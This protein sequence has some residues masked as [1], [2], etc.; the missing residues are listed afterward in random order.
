MLVG[1]ALELAKIEVIEDHEKEIFIEHRKKY[2]MLR[3]SELLNSQRVESHRY[4]KQ[5]EFDSRMK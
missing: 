3:Q 5:L 2:Q 1:K 4:R